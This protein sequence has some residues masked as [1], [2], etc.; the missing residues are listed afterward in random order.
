MRFV[1]ADDSRI[2]RNILYRILRDCGHLVVGIAEN[3]PQAVEHCRR[4]KPD[5]VI[6]DISMD[7]GNGDEAARIVHAENLAQHIIMASSMQMDSIREPLVA[8]GVHFLAKPFRPETLAALVKTI[9]DEAV[10]TG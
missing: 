9:A 10:S 3:G 1:I 5:A 2:P 7:G 8:L 4:E 6:L